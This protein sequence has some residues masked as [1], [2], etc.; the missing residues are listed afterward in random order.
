MTPDLDTVDLTSKIKDVLQF[1]NLGQKLFGE[2]VLGLSQ[3]SV[4]ELLS[5]PKPWSVL[6]IKGKEPFVRMLIWLNDPFNIEKLKLYQTEAKGGS[7]GPF[8]KTCCL[9]THVFFQKKN[10]RV[11]VSL[12]QP[13]C[14][15]NLSPCYNSL[16]I[17]IDV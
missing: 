11:I 1:H 13:S 5:K 12:N 6:S 7:G 8:R 16:W 3:G 4:S 14:F 10:C 15:S 9:A 17:N 2:A